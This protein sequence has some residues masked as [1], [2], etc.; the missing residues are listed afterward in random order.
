MK[1]SEILS[2]LTG[3]STPLGGVSFEPATSDVKVA[4]SVIIFLEDRRVLYDPSEIE[5]GKYCVQS[6]LG[7]RQFLAPMCWLSKESVKS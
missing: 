7:I 5:F 4:R 1:V 6:V 3:V 2:R